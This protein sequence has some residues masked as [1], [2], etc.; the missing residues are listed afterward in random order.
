[1][2]RSNT[3]THKIANGR[4][5]HTAAF[6]IAMIS[7]MLD[8]LNARNE[9]SLATDVDPRISELQR[10]IFELETKYREPLVLQILMGYTAREIAA[11]MGTSTSAVLTR[12][13]RARK[14]LHRLVNG[15]ETQ[16]ATIEHGN[17][18]LTGPECKRLKR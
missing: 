10:A 3:K 9:C 7:F 11:V 16:V 4:A 17:S 1:M 2:T 6:A 14:K 12:L 15:K 13:C 5:I 8:D 18:R